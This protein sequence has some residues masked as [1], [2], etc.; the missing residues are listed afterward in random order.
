MTGR[1]PLSPLLAMA[2]ALLISGC[3]TSAQ[4]NAVG[5]KGPAA[6]GFPVT[7]SNCGVKTTFQRPPQRV[8]S[9]NQHATE[10]MLALGLERSMVGTGY[11]DDE[12]LPEYRAAYD[13]VKVLSK[14]Y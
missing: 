14:E 9:L 6:K 11:L 7:V 8:V 1:R 13:K 4:D 10:V 3:G 12:I 5:A 2:T